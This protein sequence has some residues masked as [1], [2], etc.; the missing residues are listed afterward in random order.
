LSKSCLK[1]VI[2][3]SK[4]WQKV[5]KN[6]ETV[7]RGRKKEKKYSRKKSKSYKKKLS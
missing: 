5:S 1:A 4:S 3:L 6:P 7:K 2:K